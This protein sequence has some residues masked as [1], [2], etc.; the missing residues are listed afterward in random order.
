MQLATATGVPFLLRTF[1][2]ARE[3]AAEGS[4]LDWALTFV[5]LGKGWEDGVKRG[6]DS[7][8]D[9]PRM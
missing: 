9:S 8:K 7:I 2:D 3:A 6:K 4:L 5:I 1:P